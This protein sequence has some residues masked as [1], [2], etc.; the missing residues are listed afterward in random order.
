MPL[1]ILILLLISATPLMAEKIDPNSSSFVTQEKKKVRV[2]T[3]DFDGI[4]PDLKDID[5]DGSKKKE[6]LLNLPGEYPLLE[7]I[8]Y[9]A[10]FGNLGAKLTGHFPNLQSVEIESVT[11]Y[12]VLDLRGHWERDCAIRVTGSE[13]D[14]TIALPKDV[15]VVVYTESYGYKVQTALRKVGRGIF[16]K[17][18]VNEV[19]GKSPVTLTV[20]VET[21]KGK[22]ILQ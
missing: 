2:D 9:K 10:L 15:G 20:Y 5:I 18:F 8:H 17:T 6:V 12:I 7:K 14:I 4:Y 19:Y 21:T 11:A 1:L 3:Y 13:E 16:S 22:I